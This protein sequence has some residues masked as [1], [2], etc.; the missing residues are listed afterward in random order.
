MSRLNAEWHAA[1]RMPKN[2]SLVQRMEWHLAHAEHCACR[3][4]PAAILAELRKRGLKVP[5]RRS[6]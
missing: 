5:A 6:R 4:I 3:E 1:H 2:P